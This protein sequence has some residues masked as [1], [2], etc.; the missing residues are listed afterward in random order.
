MPGQVG[1]RQTLPSQ[2]LEARVGNHGKGSDTQEKQV[3]LS[4][5]SK[6]TA[7]YKLKTNKCSP[8]LHSK[9]KDQM[10]LPC[11]NLDQSRR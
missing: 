10:T 6:L 11:N 4:V 3:L 8:A 2:S 7:F 1:Q 9:G 5:K